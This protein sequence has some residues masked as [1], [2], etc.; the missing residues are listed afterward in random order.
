MQELPWTYLKDETIEVSG[1]KIHGTPW[2]TRLVNWAFNTTEDIIA[3][4]MDDVPSDIDILLSHAP[5]YRIGDKLQYGTY[6][7]GSTAIANALTYKDWPNLK[8]IVFG[9]IHE[10]HGHTKLMDMDFWNVAYLDAT[11]NSSKPNGVTVISDT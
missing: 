10:G 1:L 11:Y 5:P 2:V 7:V 3:S 4:K 9:H 8:H 6:H